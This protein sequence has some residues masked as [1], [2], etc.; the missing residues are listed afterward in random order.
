MRHSLEGILALLP[1]QGHK[2]KEVCLCVLFRLL[3]LNAFT[4]KLHSWC[5]GNGTSLDYV[6]K[7]VMYQGQCHETKKI[8]LNTYICRWSAF[9]YKTTLVINYV[10]NEY[11]FCHFCDLVS[12]WCRC[13]AGRGG[14]SIYGKQFDDEITDDLK[15]TGQCN[16]IYS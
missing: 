9:K 16:L 11:E 12:I 13:W 8:I 3:L 5:T 4:Y 15:H 7:K 14:A 10:T 2:S 6:G 1:R